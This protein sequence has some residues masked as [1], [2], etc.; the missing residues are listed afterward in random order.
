MPSLTAAIVSGQYK[1]SVERHGPNP[2]GLLEKI[3]QEVFDDILSYV[4]DNRSCVAAKYLPRDEMLRWQSPAP[5]REIFRTSSIIGRKALRCFY[6]TTTFHYWI[7][8]SCRSFQAPTPI[9][10]TDMIQN[11]KFTLTHTHQAAMERY[12]SQEV[13]P[14]LE[15][16]VSMLASKDDLKTCHIDFELVQADFIS[17]FI[18]GRFFQTLKFFNKLPKVTIKIRCDGNPPKP[19]D[20]HPRGTFGGFVTS[21]LTPAQRQKEQEENERKL[22]ARNKV[23]EDVREAINLELEPFWG[24]SDRIA[25]DSDTHWLSIEL[26]LEFHPRERVAK[27]ANT[28]AKG[29]E[30][31]E[32]VEMS[33]R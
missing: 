13:D 27:K 21:T 3:P 30:E 31:D 18:P 23:C 19:L 28:K 11:V 6:S 29:L 24:P 20:W 17:T 32:I 33:V 8:F 10:A 5:N 25:K 9:L 7:Q 15:D 2:D 1:P 16:V 22:M 14:K 26:G 4:F 12:R